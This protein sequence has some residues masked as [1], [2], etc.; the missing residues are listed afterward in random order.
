[1]NHV[2]DIQIFKQKKIIYAI[3]PMTKMLYFK[4]IGVLHILFSNA[5]CKKSCFCSVSKCQPLKETL[6]SFSV[7]IDHSTTIAVLNDAALL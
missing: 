7:S 4:V 1:M 3:S 5:I 6:H 2:N